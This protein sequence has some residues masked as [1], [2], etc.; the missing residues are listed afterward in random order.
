MKLFVLAAALL[1]SPFAAQV[2]APQQAAG[3]ESELLVLWSAGRDALLVDGRDAGLA[4]ALGMLDARLAELGRDLDDPTFPSEGL[5]LV[6]GL[7]AGPL[8]LRVERGAA[9]GGAP[10]V[11]AQLSCRARDAETAKRNVEQLGAFLARAGVPLDRAAGGAPTLAAFTPLG[12]LVLAAQGDTLVLAL[13]EPRK[14][15]F[16]GP[17]GLPAGAAPALH[18]RWNGRGMGELFGPLVRAGGPEAER[19]WRVLEVLGVVGPSAPTRTWSLGLASDRALVHTLVSGWAAAGDGSLALPP[20]DEADFARVPADAT[21]VRLW[22]LRPRMLL[23]LAEGLEPGAGQSAGAALQPLLGADLGQ[24]LDLFGPTAGAFASLSTGGGGLAS[25]VAFVETT[26]AERVEALLERL[27][28]LVEAAA[29]ETQGRVAVRP[30]EHAGARARTLVFPG[31]PVPLELSLAVH[32]DALW[33]ALRPDALIAA[34]DAA[35]SGRSVLAHPRLAPL[36]AEL[37]ADAVSFGFFDAPM[38]LDQG[39]GTASAL[40]ATLANALRSPYDPAREPGSILPPF[41]ALRAGARPSVSWSRLAGADLVGTTS[42]DR[43]FVAGATVALGTPITSLYGGVMG[44]GI[45][46]SIAIP[47]LLSARLAANETAAI[48]SLRSLASAEAQLAATAAID[49]DRDGEGEYGFLGELTGSRTLRGR[50]ERLEPPVLASA[51]GVLQDDGDGDAVVQ[52]SGYWFQVWLPLR[53]G[54]AVAERASSATAAKV[55][56]DAA[57]HA[58]CAYAWPVEPGATGQRAFFV[59]Q[60]GDVLAFDNADGVFGGLQGAGGCQPG[61]AS[62]LTRPDLESAPAIGR[63]AADGAVWRALE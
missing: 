39:Y 57:E 63:R 51:F 15:T 6:H 25:G 49:E 45:V 10:P 13:G 60:E 33:I 23:A 7:L 1:S 44:L 22:Q 41:A 14:E 58:W 29:G 47:K 54:S 46:S 35:G 9:G 31:L 8:C 61:F 37:P 11:Q 27:A 5:R 62:A 3:G 12:P 28:G 26:D 2:S 4:A 16:A 32:G 59:N 52:R 36:V 19:A 20:L 30:W 34:L 43:S 18:A 55:H 24:L 56:P 40:A 38:F 21:F 17:T 50:R 48:A 42:F 53:S